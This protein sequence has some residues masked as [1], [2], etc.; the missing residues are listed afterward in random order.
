[1]LP[2]VNF[3]HG[4][5]LSHNE[6]YWSNEPETMRLI[7]DL[8]VLYIKRVKEEKDLPQDQKNLLTWDAFKT[9]STTKVEDILASYATETVMVPKKMSYL[10]QPLDLIANDSLKKFE[11]KDFSKYFCSLILKELKN[12]PT[13]DVNT[14]K[15]DLRLST[16]KPLHAEVMKNEYNY[17]ASCR[18]K[19]I[20]KAGW[21]ASATTDAIYETSTKQVNVI[22]L[23]Q[24]A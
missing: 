21:K 15:V 17:F 6:K 14:I 18:G 1:M 19:K 24:F 12:D 11:K 22:N 20:I 4:F 16:L 3:P 2:N 5:T 10:L 9:Q 8:L 23:N 13:C 7:N